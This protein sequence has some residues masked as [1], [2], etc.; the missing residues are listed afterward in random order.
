MRRGAKARA[1]ANIALAKYWGKSDEALNLPAVPSVSITLDPLVTETTV[2]F[3]EQ[4]SE[5]SF[6]LDGEPAR[7]K[8]LGRVVRLLDEVRRDAGLDVKARVTSVNHFPTAAGLASSASGFAALAGAA[9]A[10]AGLEPSLDVLS[11]RARRASASAARSIWGGYVALPAGTPG[12][13]ELAARPV[14]GPEHWDTRVVVAVTAKGRKPIGSREAMGESRRTSPYYRAWVEDS[15]PLTARIVDALM[16]RDF[17]RLAPLVEQSFLAMHAVAMTTLPSI[18]YWQP[19]SVA[20]LS[21]VRRLRED[22]GVPVCATMDAGPHVKALCLAGAAERVERELASTE[23]V[24]R[25][26]VARPG[27]GLSVETFEP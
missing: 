3:D 20:A 9:S 19:G 6:T 16:E 23:G 11:A 17:E 18:L 7:D 1:C 10:A 8:E 5:D 26:L 22:E 14:A 21:T 15:E 12:E 25:T 27:P 13:D 24:L 4:L 2:V